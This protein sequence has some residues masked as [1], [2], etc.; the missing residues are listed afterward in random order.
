MLDEWTEYDWFSVHNHSKFSVK[1]ALGSPEQI[2]T[3]A[4]QLGWPAIGLT[5]HGTV[6]GIAQL[7]TA[8]RRLDMMPIPGMEAYYVHDRGDRK[9]K[10]MHVTLLAT[11]TQGW[12]NLV[13]INNHAHRNSYKGYPLLDFAD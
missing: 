10:R 7:Y 5:D 8:A 1:D 13:G 12:R 4:D 9:A 6:A 3:R 11:T 2:V